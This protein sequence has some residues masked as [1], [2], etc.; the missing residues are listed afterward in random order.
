MARV[1]VLAMWRVV[2]EEPVDG[3]VWVATVSSLVLG[4]IHSHHEMGHCE[5]GVVE[6]TLYSTDDSLLLLP[7]DAGPSPC[8]L[9][10]L[11]LYSRLFLVR[12]WFCLVFLIST[13]RYFSM[14]P[15][16]VPLASSDLFS[17]LLTCGV[18]SDVLLD[19]M[20]TWTY[21]SGSQEFPPDLILKSSRL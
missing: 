15:Q 18:C 11:L 8:L 14:F 6:D 2:M 20:L 10:Y 19:V 16:G 12:C 4:M 17:A 3:P 9:K 1:H 13:Y 5:M 21:L 7:A